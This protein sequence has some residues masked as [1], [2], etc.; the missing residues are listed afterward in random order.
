LSRRQALFNLVCWQEYKGEDY[1]YPVG[2]LG[3]IPHPRKVSQAGTLQ[4]AYLQGSSCIIRERYLEITVRRKRL[5]K[6]RFW[7]HKPPKSSQA[8]KYRTLRIDTYKHRKVVSSCIDRAPGLVLFDAGPVVDYQLIAA[9]HLQR[10]RE[11]LITSRGDPITQSP[12][13]SQPSTPSSPLVE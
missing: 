9:T 3:Y 5:E 2:P 8:L 11:G 10:V 12:V 7:F 13:L 6:P 4:Y 1:I